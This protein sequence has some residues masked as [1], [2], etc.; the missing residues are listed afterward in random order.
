MK[1]LLPDVA[2]DF[3]MVNPD[4]TAYK[5]RYIFAATQ[6]QNKR[7]HNL[8]QKAIDSCWFNGFMK[9]DLQE[10]RVVKTLQYEGEKQAG[11]V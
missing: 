5:N 1:E 7:D 2:V 8:S 6:G 10:R 3:L 11:E 4:C 9:Y